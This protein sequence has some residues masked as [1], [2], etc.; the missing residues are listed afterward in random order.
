[1]ILF[2]IASPAD[3]KTIKDRITY[4]VNNYFLKNF[5]INYP[6]EANKSAQEL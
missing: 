4:I 3:I 2:V 1:M 5:Q 6:L